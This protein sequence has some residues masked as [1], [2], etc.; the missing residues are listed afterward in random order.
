[1]R[2]GENV[3]INRPVEEIF[4]YDS[5]PQTLPEWSGVVKEVRREAQG[6]LREGD[7]YTSVAKFLGRRF[8]TR[9][10]VTAHAPPRRQSA[11]STSGPFPQE[12]TYILEEAAGG[13]TRLTL[14]AVGEPSGFFR[15]VGPLLQ[16]AGS[17]QFRADLATLRDLLEARG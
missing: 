16:R 10:E 4:T 14:V 13:G 9:L 8:E 2:V 3:E 12:Y 7:R 15:L 5:D 6:T 1:M 17:R 11:R